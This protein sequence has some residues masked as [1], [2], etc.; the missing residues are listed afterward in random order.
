M[1]FQPRILMQAKEM[2]P[3]GIFRVPVKDWSTK[4]VMA[5][6]FPE[7]EILAQSAFVHHSF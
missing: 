1:V 7:P 6:V 5:R 2:P 3:S 4:E